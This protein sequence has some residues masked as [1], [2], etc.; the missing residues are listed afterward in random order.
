M[1]KKWGR[2]TGRTYDAIK[3]LPPG[4]VYIV[5]D[6]NAAAYCRRMVVEIHGSTNYCRVVSINQ[7]S[8]INR[9]RGLDCV[10]K[11]DHAFFR[12]TRLRY[13]ECA[14]LWAIMDRANERAAKW[15]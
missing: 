9:L 13:Y 7:V 15:A 12:L 2:G 11:E 10:M 3:A 14:E 8:D 4:A 5:W 6:E 1:K